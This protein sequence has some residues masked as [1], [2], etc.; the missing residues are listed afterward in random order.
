[1]KRIS[2]I[3]LLLISF[4]LYSQTYA[5]YIPSEFGTYKTRSGEML[6]QS[7]LV[8]SSNDYELGTL[9]KVTNLA[10]NKS[11]LVRVN[12]NGNYPSINVYL[13]KRAFDK[14]AK[15]G[16]IKVDIEIISFPKSD[17]KIIKLR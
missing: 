10:N 8:C 4:T 16:I 3:L 2:T 1:M 15:A 5:T 13:T 17:Y 11:V 6:N 7:E 12:D 9:L 14:I